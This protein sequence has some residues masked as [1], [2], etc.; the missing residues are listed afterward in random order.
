MQNWDPLH[1]ISFIG[2]AQD[3]IIQ[4]VQLSKVGRY[5]VL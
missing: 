1:E 4:Q 2:E 5:F 3:N